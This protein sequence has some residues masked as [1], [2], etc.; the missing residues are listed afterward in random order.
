MPV[1]GLPGPRSS[2]GALRLLN[3]HVFTPGSNH[4][5][6][7]PLFKHLGFPGFRTLISELSGTSTHCGVTWLHV[8]TQGHQSGHCSALP[9]L[10]CSATPGMTG[11]WQTLEFPPSS[12]S[13]SL[14]RISPPPFASSFCRL[15][16]G[17]SSLR[18]C[19]QPL[20]PHAAAS[21]PSSGHGQSQTDLRPRLLPHAPDRSSSWWCWTFLLGGPT[22][23]SDP[24]PSLIVCS[25]TGVAL[26]G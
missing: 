14:P 10:G 6:C 15:L 4:L 13:R 8:H 20:A 3:S 25:P 2:S 26:P 24:R 21:R 22:E 16:I 9:R 19:H 7:L 17:S 23:D 12:R 1:R 18:F 5:H 11:C